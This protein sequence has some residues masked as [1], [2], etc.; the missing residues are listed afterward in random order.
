MWTYKGYG[1]LPDG[2]FIEKRINYSMTLESK[3]RVR[4]S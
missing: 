3:R 1:G 4:E 2:P